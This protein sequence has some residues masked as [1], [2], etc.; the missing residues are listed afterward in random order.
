MSIDIVLNLAFLLFG[1]FTGLTVGDIIRDLN[2]REG[3]DK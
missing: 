3:G 1:V 2:A